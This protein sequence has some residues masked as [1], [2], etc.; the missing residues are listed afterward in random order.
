MSASNSIFDAML[1]EF[2]GA[3]RLL[4][5]TYRTLQDRLEKFGIKKPA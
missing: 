3:A 2:D 4:G 5:L 1:Q